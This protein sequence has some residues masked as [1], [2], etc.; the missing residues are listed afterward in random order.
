MCVTTET[1]DEH[2]TLE[3]SFPSGESTLK[4]PGPIN[5][6]NVLIDQDS[7]YADLSFG[8]IDTSGKQAYTEWACGNTEVEPKVAGQ[9]YNEMDMKSYGY[10]I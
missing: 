4:V 9:N 7:H 2:C 1:G 5:S 10:D 6:V 3:D 8:Y